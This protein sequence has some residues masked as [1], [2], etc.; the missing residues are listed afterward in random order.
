MYCKGTIVRIRQ[1]AG[2]IE[3][4]VAGEVS[5]S[6][7]IDNCYVAAL[8]DPDGPGLMDREIEYEAGM[9]SFLDEEDAQAQKH[10]P[11]ISFRHPA[12]SHNPI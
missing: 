10:A 11:I 5:G 9:M 6:F 4:H 2:C 12:S 8:L 1:C 3:V 7:A